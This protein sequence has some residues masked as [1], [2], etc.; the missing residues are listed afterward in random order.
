MVRGIALPLVGSS[1]VAQNFWIPPAEA[2]FLPYCQQTSD[3]IARKETAR[4]DALSGKQAAKR[5]YQE[6]VAKQAAQLKQCRNQNWLKTQGLWIRLYE[7]DLQP[8]ALEEVLDRIVDRGY[9]QVY[10]ETFYNGQVL[11]PASDNPTAWQPVIKSAG[12][13]RAD[14]LAQIIQK[15][16]ERGLSVYSWMFAM[17]FGYSYAIQPSKQISLLRNGRGQTSLSANTLAGL[18]TDL[19]EVNP[20]EAFIDPY[21]LA[22]KQDYY[23]MVQEVL[24]RRPDGILFDYIRYPRSTGEASIATKV[25]DLW[26][27]GE[28]SRKAFYER[29]TNGKGRELI[30]R[31][32]ARGSINASD[33]AAVDKLFRNETNP[34]WQGR[35]PLSTEFRAPVGQRRALLQADL[36][37]LS[38]AHGMQ[39]VVDF[40]NAAIYPARQAGIPAGAVFFPEGNQAIGQGGFD[41]RLQPWDRFP[42]SIEWHPMVYGVCGRADCI[43]NQVQR[44]ISQA[45]PGTQVRPVLAGIWQQSISNRPPLEVQM[46]A[47]RKFAPRISAISHFA[48]SWQEPQSDRDRKFCQARKL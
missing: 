5:R 29:G 14:L 37:R 33:V 26:I 35:Q 25:Q 44:T 11:L 32:I 43:V 48:Y 1:I 47:L 30:K 42:N 39:G 15:G 19:G 12:N 3:E 17:N 8:G 2:N 9:N 18:S 31:F 23:R 22:A 38:V 21:S 13:E 46:E 6:I 7:C 40:L 24:K 16:R 10:V 27:Y 28:A 36:W 45:S 20:N 4:R 34:M 41:S